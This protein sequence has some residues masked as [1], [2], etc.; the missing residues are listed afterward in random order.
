M[1]EGIFTY[2]SEQREFDMLDKIELAY[3]IANHIHLGQ[4]D[5]SGMPYI[6]HPI[7]VMEKMDTYEEKIVALLHDVIEDGDG[8]IN[9]VY[10]LDNGFL[11]DVVNDIVRLSRSPGETVVSYYKRVKT[12]KRAIKVKIKDLE[13]NMRIVRFRDKG[14]MTQKDLSR[15]Q[16][17]HSKWVEL[18]N[19]LY[20]FSRKE[21]D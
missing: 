16:M 21:V 18:K 17:Y 8:R 2:I 13:D 5:K 4:V 9:S 15:I 12:S 19:E 1:T 14:R 20:S 11:S 3:S 7:R 10:L 6:F